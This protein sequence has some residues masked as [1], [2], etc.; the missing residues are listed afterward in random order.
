MSKIG[1]TDH[2]CTWFRS[3]L[4]RTQFVKFQEHTSTSLSVQTG[5]GQGTILGPLIVIFYIN[6]LISVLNVLK[7]NMYADDCILYTSGNEWNRMCQKIQPELYN[8][9]K[10]CSANRLRLNIDKSKILVIGSRSKLL[11]VDYHQNIL[12]NNNP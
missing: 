2:T 4:N 10:W 8:V 6:D 9:Y 3:Y 12:L 5:I 11:K 1:F 7:V